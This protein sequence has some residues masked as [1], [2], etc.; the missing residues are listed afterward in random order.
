M[1]GAER[2]RTTY[3]DAG[4][5]IDAATAALERIKAKAHATFPA[6]GAAAPIG[7]FGGVY[8]LPAGGERALVASADGIGTKIKLAFALG[9]GAHAR[10]GADLV[11]HCVND[12]LA[13]GAKPLFFLD[14][15][16]MGA[17]DDNTL[18]SLVGGMADAC[19]EN[20][21][22]LIGG[23]TA[24]MPGLYAADEYDAAGF[25]VGEVAPDRFVDGS[26]VRAGDLLLGL[27]S[28]G[29][30]TNGYSL[31]RKILGVTGET[32]HDRARL[33]EALPGA[34]TSW[35][36]ALMAPH[37]S[38]KA[39]VEPLLE[40]EMVR[41]MAHITGGGL[42]DNVPRMLTDGLAAEIWPDTWQRP[43]VFDA[44]IERGGVPATEAYRAFNM[45]IGFVIA[46]AAGHAETARTLAPATI[47]IGQ[48]IPSGGDGS[49]RVL[50]LT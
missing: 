23:E 44:L 15:V 27:P 6:S 25:I 43:L 41:G 28:G 46:I 11:N 33:H 30:Q 9:G 21:A 32:E 3:R 24:E 19:A 36:E 12:I 20:G 45:G 35:A 47:E 13:C 18:V 39:N 22:A 26:A 1:T 49:S 31:A 29:L 2:A 14:Y 16:A 42:V 48:V 5:D 38:F 40:R 4:V 50:G 7:H 10:V 37:R 8:R 34:D 17:L